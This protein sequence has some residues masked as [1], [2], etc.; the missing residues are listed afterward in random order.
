M[1][2]H[3]YLF[4]HKVE[5]KVPPPPPF[6]EQDAGL[7]NNPP[8]LPTFTTGPATAMRGPLQVC[9]PTHRSSG[10]VGSKTHTAPNT[11]RALRE[12]LG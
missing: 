12:G 11:S 10:K 5:P 8:P 6:Y 1:L 9:V 4:Q 3:M 7:C 2:K